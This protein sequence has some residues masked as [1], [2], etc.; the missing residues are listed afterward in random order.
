[1]TH[2]KFKQWMLDEVK[3]RR[4]T[5]EQMTD[6]LEQKTSFDANRTRIERQFWGQVV[7]FVSGQMQV[8]R[9]VHEVLDKANAHFPNRIV[10]FEPIGF[11]I[12]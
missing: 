2:Q 6:L 5:E 8:G 7:G 12:L 9:T 4:M 3:N 1:M 11:D 10:Y